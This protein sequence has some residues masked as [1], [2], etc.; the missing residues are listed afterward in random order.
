M[1]EVLRTAWARTELGKLLVATSGEGVCFLG[2]RPETAA[3]EFRAWSQKF[4]PGAEITRDDG[5]LGS[6]CAQLEE[7]ARGERREFELTFDLRG[8]DFQRAVWGGLLGIPFGRTISYMDLA[9]R[10]GKPG[11]SRAVGAANGANP[12]P[13]MV[14][15][16]RVVA[17]H[18]LGGFTGGLEL[19][20]RLLAL[21]GAYLP[22]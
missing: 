10:L 11:A 7:Y 17:R 13:I 5:A 19:K 8:T 4:W 14:P 22:L 15:C 9:R 3:N 12:I 21:E 2:L 18:G 20:Q 6:T 16:H 1:G